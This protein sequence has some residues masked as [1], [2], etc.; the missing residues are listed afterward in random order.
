[1][2]FN[3]Y[4]FESLIFR[5][6]KLADLHSESAVKLILGTAAQE[7]KFGTY[8]RQIKGPALGFLGMEP[9]TEI[10]IWENFLVFRPELAK[11]VIVISD[12]CGPSPG[13][14]WNLAYQILMAR[15]HYLR[16]P[17]ALPHHE[18]IEGMGKYWKNYYNTH[19]GKGTV[20]EFIENY[21]RFVL[22]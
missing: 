22:K 6:L 7:S 14:E 10:D 8:I 18:D 16:V 5:V 4:Q 19:E 13:L 11:K 9:Q 12:T 20:L 2:S 17:E 21:H 1:M 15:I 3:K